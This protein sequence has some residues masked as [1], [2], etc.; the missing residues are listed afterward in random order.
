MTSIGNMVVFTL[1]TPER[2]HLWIFHLQTNRKPLYFLKRHL[3]ELPSEHIYKLKKKSQSQKSLLWSQLLPEP[4]VPVQIWPSWRTTPCAANPKDGTEMTL[5]N[6]DHKNINASWVRTLNIPEEHVLCQGAQKGLN[7]KAMGTYVEAL[8]K[9]ERS[10][11]RARR[12][13]AASSVDLPTPFTSSLGNVL[14]PTLPRAPGSAGEAQGQDSHWDPGCRC[15]S[16]SNTGSGS[17]RYPVLW[18]GSRIEAFC[19]PVWEWKDWCDPRLLPVRCWCPLV[20]FV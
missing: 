8:V 17:Q 10:G 18:E 14:L 20:L 15:S 11:P 5:R 2:S 1:V 6:P 13:A 7:T 16:A 3:I 9:P 12:E 4:W 19:L